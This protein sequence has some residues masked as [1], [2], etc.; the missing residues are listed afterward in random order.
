[1]LALLGSSVQC[2]SFD[3]ARLSEIQKSR[4][5]GDLLELSFHVTL[6]DVDKSDKFIRELGR[7]QDIGRINLS[8][9]K[10]SF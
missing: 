5:G 6:K 4:K 10:R 3:S 1:M 9:D 2:P 7:I 8:F